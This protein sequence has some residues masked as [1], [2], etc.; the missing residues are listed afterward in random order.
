M[1]DCKHCKHYVYYEEDVTTGGL[2][3][4][5]SWKCT[6]D[7]SEAS[8]KGENKDKEPQESEEQSD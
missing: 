3:G 6:Q 4:C 2:Y 7:Q 5:N 1:K 8:N